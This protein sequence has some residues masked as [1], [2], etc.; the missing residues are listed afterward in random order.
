MDA[1]EGILNSNFSRKVLYNR[2]INEYLASI[3]WQK[4]EWDY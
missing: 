4:K 3:I 1:M 2:F